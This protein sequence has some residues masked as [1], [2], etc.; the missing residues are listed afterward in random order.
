MKLS[1]TWSARLQHGGQLGRK[2]ALAVLTG[3]AVLGG[4]AGCKVFLAPEHPDFAA[5]AQRVHNEQDQVGAFAADFVVSWL[6][7]TTTCQG[8]PAADQGAAERPRLGS[9]TSEELGG[10]N[11]RQ[12][13]AAD[14]RPRRSR[15]RPFFQSRAKVGAVVWRFIHGQQSSVRDCR[16]APIVAG[17]NPP[18]GAPLTA[19]A[20]MIGLSDGGRR[21]R[22]TH[23]DQTTADRRRRTPRRRL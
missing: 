10:R 17:R 18:E 6:T 22:S 19:G 2:A 12:L 3:L 20:D 13:R 5:I 8:Q 23:S 15:R 14:G 4:M 21:R 16:G 9:T 11:G 7:A 1:K